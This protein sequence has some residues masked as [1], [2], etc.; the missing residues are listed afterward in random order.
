MSFFK[1]WYF[2]QK[3]D[4]GPT[5]EV[6]DLQLKS[7]TKQTLPFNLDSNPAEYSFHNDWTPQVGSPT[8]FFL[9]L[10]A[11]MTFLFLRFRPLYNLH[12]LIYLWCSRTQSLEASIHHCLW[13]HL[14]L[15]N[16]IPRSVRIRALEILSF[17]ARLS[18][19]SLSWPNCLLSFDCSRKSP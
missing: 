5:S 9:Y 11:V 1:G 12:R 14:M 19:S 10:R 18:Y 15:L 4:L 8:H 7:L 16:A 13:I 2:T 17:E 3:P 6:I